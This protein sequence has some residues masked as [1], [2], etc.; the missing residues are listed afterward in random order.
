MMYDGYDRC[1]VQHT[2]YYR[3]LAVEETLFRFVGVR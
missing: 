2:K 3:L 1:T